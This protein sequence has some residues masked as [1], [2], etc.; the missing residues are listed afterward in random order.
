MEAE[1]L[2]VAT[3]MI[4]DESKKE[5]WADEAAALSACVSGFIEALRGLYDCV[6]PV[7]I[8]TVTLVIVTFWRL[9]LAEYLMERRVSA[10]LASFAAFKLPEW[11][12]RLLVG[13]VIAVDVVSSEVV[14]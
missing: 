7:I 6:V 11:C 2:R 13:R 9:E 14:E 4:E 5:S 3:A 1:V 12:L 8:D 10:R